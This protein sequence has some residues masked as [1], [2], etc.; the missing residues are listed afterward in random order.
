M[1]DNENHSE[2]IASLES[3]MRGIHS[4]VSD[5]KIT[6]SAIQTTLGDAKKTD[7]TM[8]FTG[9]GVL[10]VVIGGLWASGIEPLNKDISR[11]ELDSKDKA[12]AIL[13]Q[14]DKTDDLRDRIIN[15]ETIEKVNNAA[16]MDM[17]QHGSSSADKRLTLLEFLAEHK[18]SVTN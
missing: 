8:I 12:E 18:I 5:I 16:I 3:S 15:L 14:N 11:S 6:L 17:Q 7:W 10:I 4:D 2:R 9:I 1:A 13:K